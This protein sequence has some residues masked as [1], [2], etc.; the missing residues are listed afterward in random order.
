MSEFISGAELAHVCGFSAECVTHCPNV[1]AFASKVESSDEPT[2]LFGSEA[3][4][5]LAKIAR[6]RD[7]NPKKY[8]D[9]DAVNDEYECEAIH[10][11]LM[12]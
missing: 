9:R 7:C 3:L 4:V 8:V 12:F 1:R 11:G 6:A 10:L 2:R 5:A